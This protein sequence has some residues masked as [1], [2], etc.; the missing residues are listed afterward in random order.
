VSPDDVG[1]ESPGVAC[2]ATGLPHSPQRIAPEARVEPHVL[3]ITE[4]ALSVLHAIRRPRPTARTAGI[5][6]VR[7]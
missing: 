5:S 7:P 3:Q 4:N 1:L 6:P 2:V